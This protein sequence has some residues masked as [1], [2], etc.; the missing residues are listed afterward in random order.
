MHSFMAMGV[1]TVQWAVIGYSLSFAEGNPFVGGLDYLFLNGV[2]NLPQE[3]STIPHSVFMVFQGMFAIITPALIS[4]SIAERMK[5]GAYVAFIVLWG[6][7]VYDP[8]CHWVWG[9]GGW[10]GAMGALDFAGGTVVHISSGVSALVLALIER[11]P[12][13]DTPREFAIPAGGSRAFDT[14]QLMLV[15]RPVRLLAQPA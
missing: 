14:Q 2:G 12:A 8:I 10:L 5:F 6:T 7:L 9:P 3:G 13:I 1:M 11:V 15:V 4:G